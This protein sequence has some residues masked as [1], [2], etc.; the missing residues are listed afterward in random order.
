MVILDT[1]GSMGFYFQEPMFLSGPPTGDFPGGDGSFLYSD[2]AVAN[3]NWF[4]GKLVGGVRTGVNSRLYAAKSALA[5][6]ITGYGGAVDFGLE[7]FDFALCP[8]GVPQCEPCTISAGGY[9]EDTV[10]AER[11]WAVSAELTAGYT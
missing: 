4:P 7:T 9:T 1:S 5:N 8:Y 6:A 2:A 3:Q 11:L 10:M